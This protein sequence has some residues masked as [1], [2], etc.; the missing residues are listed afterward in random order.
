MVSIGNVRG[1]GWP[2]I[3]QLGKT[4]DLFYSA[5]AGEVEWSHPLR[6][7]TQLCG[8]VSATLEMVDLSEG[9]A[10][11][12][13]EFGINPASVS[14]YLEHYQLISPR[15]RHDLH[16]GSPVIGCDYQFISEHEMDNDAFYADFLAPDDMRYY[17]SGTLQQTKNR[18][19]L[20]SVQRNARQGHVDKSEITIIEQ[21]LPHIR[22][23]LDLSLRL[24]EI[25]NYTTQLEHALDQH[26]GGVALIAK[27]GSVAHANKAARKIFRSGTGLT[28]RGRKLVFADQAAAKRFSIV[29]RDMAASDNMAPWPETE[30][31]AARKSGGYP[32]ALSMHPAHTL[33]SVQSR[34]YLA[35]VFISDLDRKRRQAAKRVQMI[36]GLTPMET[37]VAIW[38]A[39][40][41][42]LSDHARHHDISMNTVYTHFRHLKEKAG[43]HS[44]MALAAKIHQIAK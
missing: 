28:V 21:I 6:Q 33:M 38:V 3:D 4:I 32:Y 7:L 36:L 43:C 41:K 15:L 18:F 35:I 16:M 31:L 40:G 25:Q 12:F 30:F 34:N 23:A 11:F 17:V 26:E 22:R 42:S 39:A 1:K 14:N 19:G 24:D 10:I 5:A 37:Q 2:T 20:F 44:Q 13:R 27:D 29:L 9:C 8:G